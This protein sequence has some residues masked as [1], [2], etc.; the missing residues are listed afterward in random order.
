MKSKILLSAKQWQQRLWKQEIFPVHCF[1]D[2]PRQS[3]QDRIT[4]TRNENFLP[5]DA[6]H[7]QMCEPVRACADHRCLAAAHTPCLAREQL[8]QAS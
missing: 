4:R 8:P 7:I 3:D 6:E 2:A 5:Q 1:I